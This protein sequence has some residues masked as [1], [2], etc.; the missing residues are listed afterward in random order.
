MI[1]RARQ[2]RWIS[3]KR[4][5]L[6]IPRS[7]RTSTSAPVSAYSSTAASSTRLPTTVTWDLTTLRRLLLPRCGAA[8]RPAAQLCALR[9]HEEPSRRLLTRTRDIPRAGP[10]VLTDRLA[11][12]R[13]SGPGDAERV[14]R[15]PL[16]RG[17]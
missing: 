11:A 7:P 6:P 16:R 15:G 1:P 13:R 2:V 12:S 4:V 17:H 5:V 3:P 14:V 9:A 8:H 10:G